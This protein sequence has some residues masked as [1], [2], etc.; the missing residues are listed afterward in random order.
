MCDRPVRSED[1]TDE[2]LEAGVDCFYDLPVA[3]EGHGQT[4]H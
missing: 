4:R 3:I 1:I 2:M